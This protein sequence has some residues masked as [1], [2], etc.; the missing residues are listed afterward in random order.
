M[1]AVVTG[2]SGFIGSRLVENLALKGWDIR[3]LI[4]NHS[5]KTDKKVET[6]NG[7]IRDPA[8]VRAAFKD[9]DI[10]FHLAAALGASLLDKREF[11]DINQSGTA[12]VLNEAGSSGIKKIIHFSSAGVLGEVE[13]KIA[14]K[15]DYPPAPKNTYDR[16][17]LEGEKIALK[18]A[19]DGMDI[20]VIR[21]GW[22]YG[23]GDKRTFKLIKA[24]AKKHFIL[25]TKGDIWQTPV[26]ID[27]L[28]EGT[29]LCA[30][31]GRRGEVYHLA[32]KEILTVRKITDQIADAAGVKIPSITLPLLPVKAA[33]FLLEKAFFIF[34]R[35]APLTRGKLAFFIHPKPL[36]IDKSYRDLGFDP[37]TDF[38]SGIKKTIQW[39][40]EQGWL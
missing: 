38:A 2:A 6:V 20:V 11:E 18:F 4:H 21:P 10:L 40:R 25:V 8:A 26:F 36:S 27:D 39:Y 23:P 15:E 37:K 1:R 13:K 16:T 7:D 17:K 31:K 34:N 22:V 9:K 12:N 5:L 30:E 24:V 28:I 19:A 3:V 35:E 14:A 32:G 33:A 29:L